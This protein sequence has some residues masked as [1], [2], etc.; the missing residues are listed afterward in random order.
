MDN[1]KKGDI[2]EKARV[3]NSIEE[4]E[5]YHY[6]DLPNDG[7]VKG[8]W[9]L[10]SGV[11]EY[12]GNVNFKNKKV[13]E[14]GTCSGFLC[15]EMEK[16]GAEVIAFDI[17]EKV[18]WDMVPYAQ[19]DYKKRIEEFKEYANRFKN[20]FW[21]SHNALK[22]KAKVIYG[23]VYKVPN[24]IGIVDIGTCC[25]ILLHLRDPFYALE[26][27]V[28]FVKETVIV[29][30]LL[31]S[32]KAIKKSNSLINKFLKRKKSNEFPYME[33]LP[34]HK[35]IIHKD[36][37]WTLSPEIVVRFLGILGFEDTKIIYHTKKLYGNNIKLFT[38]VG[39]RTSGNTI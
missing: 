39:N 1:K 24:E 19:Y 21:Y 12:L 10:R 33:F 18:E 26:N 28:K 23:S 15:F 8:K 4:C 27:L 20:A 16:R 30:D 22:S 7:E 17:S 37:W 9:D 34:N 25:S 3:V 11:D 29:T 38:V 32:S 35:T 2:F 36:A 14:F 5:F 13:L 31:P 6:M